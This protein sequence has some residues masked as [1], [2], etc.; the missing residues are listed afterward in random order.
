M[1]VEEN[2][3]AAEAAAAAAT[4]NGDKQ[5]HILMEHLGFNILPP[6]KYGLNGYLTFLNT[7]EN[8]FVR[9]IEENKANEKHELIKKNTT[10]TVVILIKKRPKR[11]QKKVHNKEVLKTIT[12]KKTKRL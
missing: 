8:N 10:H 12:K 4:V 2:I 1:T 5:Q 3:V 6:Y 11:L 7:A 9:E